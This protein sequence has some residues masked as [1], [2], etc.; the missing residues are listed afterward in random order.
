MCETAPQIAALF[1]VAIGKEVMAR[2]RAIGPRRGGGAGVAWGGF[3]VPLPD[4][5][6]ARACAARA[7]PCDPGR[8]PVLA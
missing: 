6:P 8:H 5:P 4:M 7:E 2:R 3:G 1:R